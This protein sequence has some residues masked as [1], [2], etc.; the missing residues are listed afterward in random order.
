MAFHDDVYMS[1]P[2]ARVGP[3]HAVVQE[4]LF[5]HACIRVHHWKT[6]MLEPGRSASRCLQRTGAHCPDQQPR[7]CGVDGV[8]HPNSG[9]GDQGV[10]DGFWPSLARPSLAMTYFG[11]S[12]GDF[13]YNL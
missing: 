5:V 12:Q 6:K 1:T 3:M 7:S 13:G 4:E 10:G 9:A 2:P 8:H 11:H